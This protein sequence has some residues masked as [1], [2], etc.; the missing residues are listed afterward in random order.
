M[1]DSPLAALAERTGIGYDLPRPGATK[2]DAVPDRDENESVCRTDRYDADFRRMPY[3]MT[4][5]KPLRKMLVVKPSALGDIIHALPFLNAVS[6]SHPE[7][8]IHWVAARGLHEILVDHPMIRKLWII[9]KNAWK[10]AAAMPRTVREIMN[11]A[12][13]LRRERF[14]IVVDLQGLLRSGLICAVSGAGM[15]LGFSDAREGSPLFYTHGVNGGR[16]VHAVTR[17]LR[18]AEALGCDTREVRF[19]LPALPARNQFPQWCG[20]DYLVIAPG[21]G[22]AA[23]QWPVRFL[24]ELAARLPLKSLVVGGASDAVLAAEVERLSNGHAV[25]IAGVTGL[26]ELAAVIGGARALVSSDTGPM[27]IAAALNVPVVAVFGPTNP[28]RT[29][30]YG[31]IHTAVVAD[32]PCSPCYKRKRCREWRCMESIGVRQVLDAVLSRL[33]EPPPAAT[34]GDDDRAAPAVRLRDEKAS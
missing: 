6:R 34:Y 10:R 20:G 32:V 12:S 30:P 17:C 33:A 29:G 9:D 31:S 27:H 3:S 18:M 26:R 11:L 21:A 19:P 2:R 14:D 5:S 22:G 28:A 7:I 15:R 8:A 1:E 23:K 24:G 13:G 25:S 16:D 4:I